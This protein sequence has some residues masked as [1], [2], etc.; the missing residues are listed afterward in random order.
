MGQ[1]FNLQ[2]WIEYRLGSRGSEFTSSE[3]DIGIA[4]ER[5]YVGRC[6][7]CPVPQR[8]PSPEHPRGADLAT[9]PWNYSRARRKLCQTTT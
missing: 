1:S 2:V 6:N 5:G 8:S 3:Y 9:L 7:N 4:A